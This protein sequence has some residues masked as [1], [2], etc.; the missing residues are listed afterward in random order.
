MK[1]Q[2]MQK[3]HNYLNNHNQ[4]ARNSGGMLRMGSMAKVICGQDTAS[5]PSRQTSHLYTYNLLLHS[6]LKTTPLPV[7]KAVLVEEGVDEGQV[8]TL[9]RDLCRP[10]C[11]FGSLK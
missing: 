10:T 7:V 6:N 11:G 4:Q 1:R 8:D 3:Q 2:N 9:E 5:Q